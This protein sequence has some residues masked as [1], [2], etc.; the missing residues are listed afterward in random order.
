MKN[1]SKKKLI[2]IF[3]I[4]SL[5][6]FL[7]PFTLSDNPPQSDN[8]Y[9]H[10]R[11]PN[12]DLEKSDKGFTR[13]SYFGN[14]NVKD[15]DGK[16]KPF[17]EV[18][19]HSKNVDTLTFNSVN[20][21]I[22]LQFIALTPAGNQMPIQSVV[23]FDLRV[24]EYLGKKKWS[25]DLRVDEYLGKKKWSYDLNLPN[26]QFSALVNVTT[27]LPLTIVDND[28]ISDELI[29]SFKDVLDYGYTYNVVKINDYNAVFTINKDWNSHG[30]KNGDFITIDPTV[31][32]N[33][34]DQ[35][36]IFAH[37]FVEDGG[38]NNINSIP[39][40]EWSPDK[41]DTGSPSDITSEA[42]LDS[43]DNSD[44][45]IDVSNGENAW[46]R[47]YVN[48]QEDTSDIIMIN[49]T[50]EGVSSSSPSPYAMLFTRNW[51]ATNWTSMADNIDGLGDQLHYP[52]I[53]SN[54]DDYINDSGATALLFYGGA[55]G[56]NEDLYTDFIKLE[57]TYDDI[58]INTPIS[59]EEVLNTRNDTIN[60]SSSGYNDTIWYSLNDGKK[61]TTIC[62]LSGEC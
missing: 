50:F 30:I 41:C 13:T 26:T 9:I 42:S 45:H 32:Y 59:N 28:V 58:I 29:I 8:S 18:I 20:S 1:E 10:S 7:I 19:K 5:S 37:E 52:N 36:N 40:A 60:T 23:G 22:T 35:T 21:D 14:V 57:I 55:S 12:W 2:S 53:S 11:G 16:Y 47:F 51:S 49:W 44:S 43:S 3:A 33:F 4:L 39:E 17:N 24:D 6:L 34:S 48:V 62:T 56:S 38:C 46:Q 31:T 15:S 54:I 25:Y 27:E 61:N